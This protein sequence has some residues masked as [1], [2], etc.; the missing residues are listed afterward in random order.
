MSFNRTF[1]ELKSHMPFSLSAALTSFNR[2]FMELKLLYSK[3]G[4][5]KDAF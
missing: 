5:E 2:T 1:M 4:G 3:Q